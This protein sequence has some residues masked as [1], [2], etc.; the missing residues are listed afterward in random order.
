MKSPDSKDQLK[1]LALRPLSAAD[2]DLPVGHLQL[3]TRTERLL[4][5]LGVRTIGQ[6]A[7]AV[8]EG[9]L[10]NLESWRSIR[11]RYRASSWFSAE[12]NEGART[13]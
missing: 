8:T 10:A 13:S 6:L 9:S 12:P 5:K 7:N 4:R 1:R 3:S 2:A 11:R